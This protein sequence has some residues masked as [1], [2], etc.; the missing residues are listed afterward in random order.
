MLASEEKDFI[1]E[2]IA[3]LLKVDV[4]DLMVL[5]GE[6]EEDGSQVDIVWAKPT[7]DFNYHVLVTAG[8]SEMVMEEPEQCM[9]LVMMLPADWKMGDKKDEWWWPV[10]LLSGVAYT[11]LTAK[12]SLT[13]GS[14]LTVI[15]EGA[16]SNCNELTTLIIPNNITTI[17]RQAFY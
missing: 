2:R 14:G 13:I 4:D 12:E 10:E 8:L 11:A 16:F 5:P 7:K 17:E 9:E 3:R 1:R 15:E 6:R